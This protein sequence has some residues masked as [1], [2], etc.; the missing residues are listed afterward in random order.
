[1]FPFYSFWELHFASC[2][3]MVNPM[4]KGTPFLDKAE[5]PSAFGFQAAK[6][7]GDYIMDY[8]LNVLT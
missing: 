6:L 4:G 3:I 7:T 8:S 2:N 1:M 5:L